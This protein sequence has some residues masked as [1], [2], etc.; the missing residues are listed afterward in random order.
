MVGISYIKCISSLYL[1]LSQ[2]LNNNISF[3]G[4][5]L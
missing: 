4:K 2:N 3:Y 5:I 1:I